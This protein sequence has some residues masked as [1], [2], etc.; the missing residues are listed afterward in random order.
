MAK[1]LFG[2]ALEAILS[3]FKENWFE[4]ITKLWKKIPS[5]LQEKLVDIVEIVERIKTYVDSPVVDFIASVIPGD[6]DDKIVSTLRAIL[7]SIIEELKLIDT[8]SSELKA[9]D[10]QSIATRL[11]QEVTGLPFGQA[12]ITIENTY[13]N[14]QKN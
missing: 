8:P 11:T 13:Q 1:T 12:A 3:L 2:K 5:E 6:K 10:L 9:T 4:F 7:R 14:Y